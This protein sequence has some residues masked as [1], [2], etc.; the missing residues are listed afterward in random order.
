MAEA[1]LPPSDPH[2]EGRATICKDLG[3]GIP[4]RAG[5]EKRK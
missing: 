3:W 5:K 4:G 1:I 2:T